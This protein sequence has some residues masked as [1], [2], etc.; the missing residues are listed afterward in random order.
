MNIQTIVQ[1]P[2]EP[3]TLAEAYTHLRWDTEDEGSPSV[4]TYPLGALVE[5]NITSARQYVEQTTRQALVRQTLKMSLP[6]FP[7]ARGYFSTPFRY[8]LDDDD[9]YAKPGYVELPRPPYIEIVSVKYLD[10]DEVEQTL[11]P[12]KYYID[13][14]SGLAARLYFRDTLDVN[15][16]NP[17][18]EDSVR[19]TW[20]AGYPPGAD[21]P[22]NTQENLSVNVPSAIKDAI[23]IQTQLLCDRFDANERFD[24]ERARDRLLANY[25]IAGW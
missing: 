1:P 2:F 12:A 19:I 20:T 8:G 14:N 7:A 24:L 18:R 9:Y 13:T 16:A 22:D 23:L 21:S 3:I 10:H 4:V 11:D 5:R 15:I 17:D 25:T 6:G